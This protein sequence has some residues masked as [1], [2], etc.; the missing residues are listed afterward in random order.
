MALNKKLFA[1][2]DDLTPYIFY[3]FNNNLNDEQGNHDGSGSDFTY[4]STT[5]VKEGQYVQMSTTGS[6]P[7]TVG[8]YEMEVGDSFSVFLFRPLGVSDERI[9]IFGSHG[10]SAYEYVSLV[11]TET[12]SGIEARSF[13][14]N[15]ASNYKFYYSTSS[16]LSM[17][18]GTWNHITFNF[19]SLAHLNSS[20]NLPTNT[21]TLNGN[22][23]TLYRDTSAGTLSSLVMNDPMRFGVSTVKESQGTYNYPTSG[24]RFDYLKIFQ[25]Y[26]LTS[27]DIAALGSEI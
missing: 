13:F 9:R 21:L 26:H 23:V 4:G 25:D 6:S 1:K 17:T 19:P 24:N 10:T 14:R 7:L 11:F 2:T 8:S 20:S 5:P 22:N 15:D 16:N 18:A 3:K 27:D 12:T